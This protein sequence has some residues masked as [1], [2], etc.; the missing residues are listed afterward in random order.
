MAV[1]DACNQEMLTAATCYFNKL[2]LK[3]GD[4]IPR[5]RYDGST[6]ERCGDCGVEI[7]GYHHPGCD[8]AECTICNGQESFCDCPIKRYKHVE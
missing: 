8:Q 6:G 5:R 7:N 2:L 3:N 1:C 4:I